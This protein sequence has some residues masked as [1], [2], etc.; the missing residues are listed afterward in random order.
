MLYQIRYL[1]LGSTPQGT[2]SVN[3]TSVQ[4][5]IADAMSHH[6]SGVVLHTCKAD[7]AGPCTSFLTT[8]AWNYLDVKLVDS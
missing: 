6:I 5:D 4:N 2:R 1:I 3:F 7:D 8:A